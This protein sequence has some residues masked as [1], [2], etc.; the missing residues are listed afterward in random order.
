MNTDKK[1]FVELNDCALDSVAGGYLQVSKWR[2]Y[3]TNNILPVIL[4]AKNSA[5]ASDQIIL[6][7]IYNTI[8]GTLIPGADVCVPV[9]NLRDTFLNS[10]CYGVHS[11]S[12]RSTLESA[13]NSAC[14]YLDENA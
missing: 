10:T 12:V 9:R 3:A 11:A 7:T 5:D 2:T 8:Q 13:L 1:G 6:D 4:Q 14:S